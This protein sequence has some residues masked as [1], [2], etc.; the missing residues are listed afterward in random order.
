MRLCA[1]AGVVAACLAVAAPAAAQ[2]VQQLVVFRSGEAVQK[3]SIKA[4]GTKVHVGSRTCAVPARTPLAVLVRSGVGPL[5]L[6]DYGRCSSKPADAAG[7]YVRK[8]RKDAAHGANGW[9]YKVG[10][11]SAPAGAADPTGPFG[12]G[13]LKPGARVTWFYCHMGAGGCQRTLDITKVSAPAQDGS[14]R[15]T[16]TAF[17]DRGDGKPAAG[18]TVHSGDATARTN[19]HGVATIDPSGDGGMFATKPGT[20]RSFEI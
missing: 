13:R 2:T 15:V 9:V 20:V 6:H 7:L 19:S 8:I 18:A 5:K 10:H 1:A 12:H 16:V 3:Q 11:T 17:D 14:V 4:A